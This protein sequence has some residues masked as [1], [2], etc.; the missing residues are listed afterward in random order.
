MK[1]FL[2]ILLLFVS[3]AAQGQTTVVKGILVDSLSREGEPAA[4]LQFF[5]D[6]EASRPIAFTVTDETGR[7]THPLSGKGEHR[8]LFTNMGRKQRSI[9][10]NLT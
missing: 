1:R 3:I 7:F 10:F 8:M 6:G 2:F 5:K 9:V 4:V